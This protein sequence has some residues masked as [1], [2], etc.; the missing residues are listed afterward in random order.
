MS[1]RP[2]FNK[3]RIGRPVSARVAYEASPLRLVDDRERATHASCYALWG[4]SP[5]TMGYTAPTATRVARN[6]AP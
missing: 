6:H 4:K 5:P 3:T 1:L 2:S